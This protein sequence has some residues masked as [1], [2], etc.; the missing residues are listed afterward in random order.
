MVVVRENAPFA[1]LND[2]R[3]TGE[4][5]RIQGYGYCF[6]SRF[7]GP[8]YVLSSIASESIANIL[9]ERVVQFTC[10]IRTPLK[11]CAQRL[12][13]D[14]LRCVC[15]MFVRAQILSNKNLLCVSIFCA[16][17]FLCQLSIRRNIYSFLFIPTIVFP[18]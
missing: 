4:F 9:Y 11:R 15:V 2:T 3:Y 8:L 12:I 16:F 17:I 13:S 7:T 1:A 18:H 14:E 6:A 10:E 5:Q